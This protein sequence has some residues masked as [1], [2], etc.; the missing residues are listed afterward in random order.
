MQY[1]QIGALFNLL[2]LLCAIP[3]YTVTL[4]TGQ[5]KHIIKLI[6]FFTVWIPDLA[7]VKFLNISFFDR[8]CV[9]ASLALHPSVRFDSENIL[10][11][12]VPP[13]CFALR[14]PPRHGL[15]HC[16]LLTR[17]TEWLLRQYK[18]VQYSRPYFLS[19]TFA[20]ELVFLH[21]TNTT[22]LLR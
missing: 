1:W 8:S 12:G 20:L 22:Y 19:Q 13:S 14:A 7:S 18:I 16:G 17:E 15:W 10:L 4:V 2:Q 5:I 21:F 3:V 9:Q 11:P 6:Y